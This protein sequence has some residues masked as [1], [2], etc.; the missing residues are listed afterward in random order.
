MGEVSALR[1]WWNTP[2]VTAAD[3]QDTDTSARKMSRPASGTWAKLDVREANFACAALADAIAG[4]CWL[5]TAQ[6]LADP[7]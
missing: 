3:V 6:A 7:P 5:D 2:A 4:L 1:T